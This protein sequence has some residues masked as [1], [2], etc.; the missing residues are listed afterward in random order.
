MV[1]RWDRSGRW[2]ERMDY[3]FFK[4]ETDGFQIFSIELIF[5]LL[6]RMLLLTGTRGGGRAW[7]VVPSYP[8]RL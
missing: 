7:S 2:I 3:G 5:P 4:K 6:R 1:A 8:L